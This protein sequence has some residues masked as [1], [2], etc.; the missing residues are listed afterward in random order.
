M[1]G[2]SLTLTNSIV[3]GNLRSIVSGQFPTLAGDECA[4][5]LSSLGDNLLSVDVDTSHCTVAGSYGTGAANFGPLDDNGG[6][7]QT[8]A[9][10]GGSAAID[11]G[12]LGGCTDN[13]GAV[14]TRDQ[15]GVKRPYG[16][17]CD[18]G[19]FEAAEIIFRDGFDGS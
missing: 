11:A 17:R 6:L 14:L 9:L 8:H 3:Q 4:G 5:S 2:N 13:V 15:R 12:N 10:L 7:T 19:A 18:L 1:G 16:G